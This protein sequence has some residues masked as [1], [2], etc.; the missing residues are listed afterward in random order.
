MI[1]H[2]TQVIASAWGDPS[3]ITDAVCN[4]GY[5]KADR[6]SEEMVLMTLK[7]IEYSHYSD[8]PYEYWP[9]DLES[10]LAAELNFLIDD[11]TWSDKTTPATVARV[12]LENGYQR[13]EK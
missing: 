6:T 12:I 8:I 11:L 5:R 7:V 2:L 13:G 4:A 1:I 3:D 10:V 9:K